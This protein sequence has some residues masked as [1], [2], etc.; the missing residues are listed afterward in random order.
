M[1]TYQ[2]INSETITRVL[3]VQADNEDDAYDIADRV[4]SDRWE[5]DEVEEHLPDID[6]LGPEDIDTSVEVE[7][8]KIYTK[9]NVRQ[10]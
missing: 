4:P 9:Q 8:F 1:K 2:V 3:Y 7:G 5:I 6:E 10:L